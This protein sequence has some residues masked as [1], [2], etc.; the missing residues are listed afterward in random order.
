MDEQ[1]DE[2]YAGEDRHLALRLQKFLCREVDGEGEDLGD[3]G[4]G[5]PTGGVGDIGVL[6]YQLQDGGG[7][8]VEGA[9][10]NGGGGEDDP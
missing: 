9:H 5:K 2:A 3:N 10:K 7:E 6:A 8:E 4:D 1:C